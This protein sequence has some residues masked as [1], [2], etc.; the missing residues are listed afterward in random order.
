MS[1]YNEFTAPKADGAFYSNPLWMPDIGIKD[2]IFSRLMSDRVN[3]ETLNKSFQTQP[4]F[5]GPVL[6]E[7]LL[8]NVK[9]NP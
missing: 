7:G 6:G 9:L 2:V 5:Q 1:A 4:H 3:P 8:A